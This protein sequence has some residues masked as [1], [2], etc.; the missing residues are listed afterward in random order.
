MEVM[1]R[2]IMRTTTRITTRPIPRICSTSS[3]EASSTASST[4]WRI[5]SRLGISRIV[6]TCSSGLKGDS[7]LLFRVSGYC[8]ANA[9]ALR[10]AR[11]GPLTAMTCSPDVI[12]T[13]ST[14]RLAIRPTTIS[15]A[16]CS[17]SRNAATCAVF[18]TVLIR[19]SSWRC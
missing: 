17:S 1:G 12:A 3:P 6:P 7:N 2:V 9:E 8:C 10:P 13:P 4:C 11:F 14:V 19:P 18:S 15:L 16:S 5:T